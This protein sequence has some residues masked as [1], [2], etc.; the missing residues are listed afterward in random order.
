MPDAAVPVRIAFCIT[1]LDPGG[2]ERALARLVTGLDRGRWEPRV[3]CLSSGGALADELQAA[4]VPVVCFG[5]RRWNH[6]PVLLRLSRELKRFR[7]AILQTFLYHANLAGR[8]A[9]RMARIHTIVSGIRVAEKRSRARLW[10]DRWTNRLV[11][12][13]VCVS[14]AVAAFSAEQS[15]LAAEKIV[16]IPNGVDVPRFAGAA[17]A[18]LSGLGIPPGSRTLLSI[19]R[20]DP[21]KGLGDLISAAALIIHRFPDAHFLVVGEGPER[22][23]L[24]EMIREQGLAERVHLAGWRADIPE[25]LAAGTALVLASHWEGL[26]NVI[27]EAMA[28]GLPV[29]ATRVEGTDELV[30]DGQTG[31]V[32][33]PRSPN[34]LAESIEKLLLDPAAAKVMGQGGQQRAKSEFTWEAMVVQYERLYRSLLEPG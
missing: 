5:A 10:L 21:Q 11:R 8:I 1:D 16:V 30:I 12:L 9:G 6:V 28:A 2:A 22:S 17:P 32:V 26:P 19:G 23:R 7:P 31:L 3:F 33:P 25:L 14:R 27:L 15:G 4:K 29:V 34:D 20:L 13:N 18:D 24:D